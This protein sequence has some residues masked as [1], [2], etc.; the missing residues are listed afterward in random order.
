MSDEARTFNTMLN[1]NGQGRDATEET[2]LRL[3]RA[4]RIARLVRDLAEL[5]SKTMAIE[6]Q[7]AQVQAELMHG[8][9]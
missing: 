2:R 4:S 5:K 6:V 8:C 3:A 1:V 9:V 7:L